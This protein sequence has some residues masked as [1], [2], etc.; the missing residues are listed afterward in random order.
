MEILKKK[1]KDKG[2]LE[3]ELLNFRHEINEKERLLTRLEKDLKE[4][5]KTFDY[6]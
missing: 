2:K 5:A 4:K 1:R 3:E 6:M